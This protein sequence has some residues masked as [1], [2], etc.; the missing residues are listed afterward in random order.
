MSERAYYC[1]E[2]RSLLTGEGN[3][4]GD[5]LM[6]EIVRRD[7]MALLIRELGLGESSQCVWDL[8][9]ATSDVCFEMVMQYFILCVIFFLDTL[10]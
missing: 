1:G 6:R 8:L 2:V 7:E 10:G 9:P 5:F 4:T 3:K